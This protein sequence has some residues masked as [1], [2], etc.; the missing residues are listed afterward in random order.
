[1]IPIA[2]APFSSG[3]PRRP[4]AG[5]HA[6]LHVVL[7][8]GEAKAAPAEEVA[9]GVRGRTIYL[10]PDELNDLLGM[11]EPPDA[12]GHHPQYALPCCIHFPAGRTQWS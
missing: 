3:D 5:G 6:F 4:G 8:N 12:L 1:M 11:R 10:F 9:G 2:D 7:L